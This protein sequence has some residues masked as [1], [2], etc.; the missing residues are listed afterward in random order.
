MFKDVP[1]EE[2]KLFHMEIQGLLK[3][4]IILEGRT[5]WINM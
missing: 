1:Q 2:T 5:K 4:L 3:E